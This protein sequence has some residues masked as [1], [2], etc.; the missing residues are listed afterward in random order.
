MFSSKEKL[1]QQHRDLDALLA[2]VT[3]G[4]TDA[5]IVNCPSFSEMVGSW[6]LAAKQGQFWVVLGYEVWCGW[7]RSWA[8]LVLSLW[9]SLQYSCVFF[10]TSKHLCI[11]GGM[12]TH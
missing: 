10:I 8:K 9:D 11:T 3:A 1:K 12:Q 2:K 6:V 7:I 4:R 5:C